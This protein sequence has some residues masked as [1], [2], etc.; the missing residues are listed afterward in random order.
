ML[1]HHF[2]VVES[3]HIR[4]RRY[5]AAFRRQDEE[6]TT[7]IRKWCWQT[8]GQAGYRVNSDETRWADSLKHG[9]IMFEREE[10]LAVFLLKWAS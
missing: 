8:F 1:I 4:C 10:D 9:E 2:K 6:R 5:I 7:E 3:G